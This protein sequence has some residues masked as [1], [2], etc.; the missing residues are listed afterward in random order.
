MIA[1][2]SRPT[3]S[4]S[5][6]RP[7]GRRRRRS[8]PTGTRTRS[9]R[10]PLHEPRDARERSPLLGAAADRRLGRVL[11]RRGRCRLAVAAPAR[12]A[13]TPR[14]SSGARPPR[15]PNGRSVWSETSSLPW[16]SPVMTARRGATPRTLADLLQGLTSALT[17]SSTIPGGAFA[18]SD[19]GLA[20][21]IPVLARATRVRSPRSRR[22][23]H[24][25]TA[26]GRR[27]ALR[28]ARR[29]RPGHAHDRP[30]G[31]HRARRPERCRQVDAAADRGRA[32]RS[33]TRAS[34][35]RAPDAAD[36]RLSRA[37]A[38][39]E[40]G[41]SVLDD[42]RPAHGRRG[43]ER[44]LEDVG[45]RSAPEAT[46]RPTLL[47]CA[48]APRRAR[49]A[50]L[51]GS[52]PRRRAPSSGSASTSTASSTAL[53]GGEAAR[54]ALAAIL[55]SR[56]DVLLLDEPTNDLDFDGLERL[57]RFLAA[58]RGALVVVSHDREFLDRTV[59]RIAVDRAGHA[60]RAG[61]GGRLERLRDGARHRARRR[62][63]GVRAGAASAQAAHDAPEHAADRG[64]LEGRLAR[65][66]DGRPGPA[67]DACARDE[68][69]AGRA[70]PRAQ[71]AAGQA[72]R[73]VGAEAHAPM[74]DPPVRSRAPA[75]G[76]CRRA[77]AHSASARS[78]STSRRASGCRSSGR[79]A[80]AS[81]RCWACSSAR[82]R[83]SQ[84]SAS[85]AGAR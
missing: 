68:G 31:T 78:T 84:A 73:A 33:P 81:R 14:G 76:R 27:Q 83:S 35:T 24:A 15:W 58:Y 46:W 45:T 42:A 21:P 71:R 53:S 54:V 34:V 4:R 57:E 56:F 7:A 30:E 50:R 26:R 29:S 19:D 36:R 22:S 20:G 18:P 75:L 47:G 39:R 17:A 66:Q 65:R 10:V 32:W 55:L 44:E 38:R 43:A 48:R 59:D 28:R 3:R 1:A 77:V 9:A 52:R 74:A 12:R 11:R 60:A 49:R 16:S 13:R 61:V 85:S 70:A 37:G 69:A 40:A 41:E 2:S 51:R 5:R 67:G 62:A 82:C 80:P 64:A 72:V 79:T 63:R 8:A 25:G 6:L 23:V